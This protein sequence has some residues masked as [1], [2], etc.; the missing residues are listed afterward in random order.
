[1]EKKKIV[2]NL[3]VL[4]IILVIAIIVTMIIIVIKENNKNIE[5]NHIVINTASNQII[6]GNNTVDNQ[7]TSG[8]NVDSNET[9]D[10]EDKYQLTLNSNIQK[11]YGESNYVML[12]QCLNT[13]YRGIKEGD[14]QKVI[15]LLSDIYKAN[16]TD[17]SSLPQGFE[18]FRITEAYYK[19]L[20]VDKTEYYVLG[21]LLWDNYTGMS[22][23]Y[24]VV[25]LDT[26]NNTF[27]ITPVNATINNQ[28]EY[29][30]IINKTTS[31]NA[32]AIIKN[33]NNTIEQKSL[34]TQEII[35]YYL[36]DYT[37]MAIYYSEIGYNLLDEEYRTKKFANIE[38]YKLYITQN[39]L[40]M[41]NATVV[42]Y[43]YEN[44]EDYI[45]YT[46]IDNYNNTYVIKRFDIMNYKVISD[47]YTVDLN[48]VVQKYD[49]GTDED[50][51]AIN[52]QKIVE[53]FNNKDYKYVYSKL[54]NM[55]KQNEYTT[56]ETF[57]NSMNSMFLR[58]ICSIRN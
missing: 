8:N 3:I 34:T 23:V 47:I 16:N 20:S 46:I 5:E 24:V 41:E 27:S 1:M 17:V 36:N 31:Q 12:E 9:L 21:N 32:N 28:T 40:R 53:A 51:V 42:Q 44:K 25:T 6:S 29:F 33:E 55:S 58:Y 11:V 49:N 22:I 30:D 7:N 50:K 26:I 2:F 43:A 37:T 45:E 57:E 38:D 10:E 19:D 13:Y 18:R 54:S 15:N 39:A 56:L 14:V 48:I 52:I 35:Q 4:S